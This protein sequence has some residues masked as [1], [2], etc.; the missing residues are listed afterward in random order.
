MEEYLEIPVV[1]TV[2]SRGEG[3]PE[4]L[5]AAIKEAETSPHHEHSIGYGNTTEGV[6]A[7]AAAR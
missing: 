3:I 2:G 1:R 4:L 5:G 7:A 6:I